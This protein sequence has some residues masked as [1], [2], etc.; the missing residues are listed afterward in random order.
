MAG[1]GSP[2]GSGGNPEMDHLVTP[3]GRDRASPTL[4][5]TSGTGRG[6]AGPMDDPTKT[7]TKRN[8]GSILK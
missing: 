3:L 2:V 1:V 7:K 4:S 5:S 8:E 6:S